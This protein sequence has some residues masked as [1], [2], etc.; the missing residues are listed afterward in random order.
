MSDIKKTLLKL[1]KSKKIFLYDKILKKNISYN[2]FFLNSIKL[3]NFL[4]V[5]KNIKKFVFFLDKY[6]HRDTLPM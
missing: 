5:E 2:Q 1:S 4:K 3:A 6:F